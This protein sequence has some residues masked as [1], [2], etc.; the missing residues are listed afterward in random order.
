MRYN[1]AIQLKV[2]GGRAGDALPALRRLLDR[3][4]EPE[5]VRL[6][7]GSAVESIECGAPALRL[8]EP[9]HS[10]SNAASRGRFVD[11]SVAGEVRSRLD[12][13]DFEDALTLLD[14]AIEGDQ[15]SI[16]W[17]DLFRGA[18]ELD[19]PSQHRYN[20]RYLETSGLGG[21]WHELNGVVR[22]TREVQKGM[23]RMIRSLEALL[24]ARHCR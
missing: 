18:R 10:L 22:S 13:D 20:E 19:L 15:D 21:F 24:Q 9:Y 11:A 23:R 7:A 6:Q 14:D 5:A 8:D 1:A 2:L 17:L 4:N 16:V 3:E 12:K